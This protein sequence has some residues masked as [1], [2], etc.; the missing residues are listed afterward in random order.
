MSVTAVAC[1]TTESKGEGDMDEG[2]R[3]RMRVSVSC[4]WT[5]RN[6]TDWLI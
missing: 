5:K 6:V 3:E 2:G 4:C 1:K